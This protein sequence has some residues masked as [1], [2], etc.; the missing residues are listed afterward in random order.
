VF[1]KKTKLFTRRNSSVIGQ[2]N[3]ETEKANSKD[4]NENEFEEARTDEI[5]L[6]PAFN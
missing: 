1:E 3:R 2:R 5:H 6:S 4:D